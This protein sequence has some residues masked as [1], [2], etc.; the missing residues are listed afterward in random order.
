MDDFSTPNTTNSFG[1]PASPANF[2]KAGKR[3][4]S[5]M[6]PSIVLDRDGDVQLIVGASGDTQIIT[7][8]ALVGTHACMHAHTRTHLVP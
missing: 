4:L 6:C 8:T 5:S 7:S 2:I 1:L 3:P